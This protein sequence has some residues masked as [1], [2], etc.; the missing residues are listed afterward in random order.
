MCG[1]GG[2]VFA[3]AT[4]LR[5]RLEAMNA[6]MVHRGPDDAGVEL[7][8][9]IGAGLAARRLS[10]VD[11]EAGHQPM[12]NQDGSIWAVLNGEIYNHAALREQLRERGYRFRSHCDT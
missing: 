10:L 12:S 2:I 1:V 9:Q 11:L 4:D 7:F 5:E 6:S 3:S 8:P